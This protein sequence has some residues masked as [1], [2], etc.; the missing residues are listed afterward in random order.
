MQNGTIFFACLF[1]VIL[2]FNING[3][4]K[5]KKYN[6]YDHLNCSIMYYKQC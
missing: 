4:L 6:T 1:D 2:K 5:L 3:D